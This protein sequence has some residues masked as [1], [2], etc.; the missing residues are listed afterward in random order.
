MCRKSTRL[1]V[2]PL[3]GDVSGQADLWTATGDY[4]AFVIDERGDDVGVVRPGRVR[5]PWQAIRSAC[6][7]AVG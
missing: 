4:P 6:L 3:S 1:A 5:T 7:G 2:P